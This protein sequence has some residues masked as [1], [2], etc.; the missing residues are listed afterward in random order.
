MVA[1]DIVGKLFEA[2]EGVGAVDGWGDSICGCKY[3][4]RRLAEDNTYRTGMPSRC[5]D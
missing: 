4:G 5:S 3:N 2:E 1:K